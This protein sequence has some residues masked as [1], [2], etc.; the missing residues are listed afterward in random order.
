[1]FC[2]KC[3]QQQ[4][5][6]EAR[7]CSR[8]GFQLGVVKA[9]LGADETPEV[10]ATQGGV[11]APERRMKDKT[12]GAFQMFLCAFVVAAITVDMPSSHSSR[13]FFLVIAWLALTLLLNRKPIIRYFYPQKGADAGG[14]VASSD[15]AFDSLLTRVDTSRGALPSATAIPVSAL[16]ARRADTTEVVEPPSVTERTTNLLKRQ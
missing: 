16:A 11:V 13:I 15:A 6:D 4:T 8:C 7:F 9:L 2:P 12:I 1:M 3:S 14:H 5:S 10:R